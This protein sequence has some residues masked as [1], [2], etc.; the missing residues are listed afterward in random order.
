MRRLTEQLRGKR[1]TLRMAERDAEAAR[2]G[3][4]VD[5]SVLASAPDVPSLQ[6]ECQRIEVR[7]LL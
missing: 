5:P 7:T 6:K 2:K 4:Y 1:E 3:Y